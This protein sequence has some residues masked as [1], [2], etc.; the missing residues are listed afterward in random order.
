MTDGER[1]QAAFRQ[2]A[3]RRT[4]GTSSAPDSLTTKGDLLTRA[5]AA[6]ARLPVGTDNQSLVAD[7]AATTGLK[8]AATPPDVLTTKGDLLSRSASGYTRT[9]VGSDGQVLV[10]DA[11]DA[12]G[13]K[14]R[15]RTPR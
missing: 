13:V 5:A 15:T 12:D 7:A 6:Y 11:A 1:Q 9:P 2:G 3:K 4:F 14:W 8:W 10:A